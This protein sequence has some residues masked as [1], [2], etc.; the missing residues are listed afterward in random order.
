MLLFKKKLKNGTKKG[1]FIMVIIRD[2]HVKVKET[3]PTNGFANFLTAA[4]ALFKTYGES[5]LFFSEETITE[6]GKIVSSKIIFYFSEPAISLMINK[7]LICVPHTE[8]LIF[9]KNEEKQEPFMNLESIKHF[10]DS[11]SATVSSRSRK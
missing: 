10:R 11:S 6:Q 5:R 9:E 2:I 1:K 8:N 3:A 7:Y 4:R